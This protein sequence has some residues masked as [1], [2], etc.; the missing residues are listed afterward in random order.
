MFNTKA[1][2]FPFIGKWEKTYK[3]HSRCGAYLYK[4]NND[5]AQWCV[6]CNTGF[7]I[8]NPNCCTDCGADLSCTPLLQGE[9][10]LCYKCLNKQGKNT[11]D[12]FGSKMSQRC[13]KSCGTSYESNKMILYRGN[14]LLCPG[15][16]SYNVSLETRSSGSGQAII[17]GG[18]IT[19]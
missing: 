9:F 10:H 11:I 14:C 13:C 8:L 4:I 7:N 18:T 19:Y 6:H 12:F 17:T 3:K 2:H 5:T 15:C 16:H 1:N